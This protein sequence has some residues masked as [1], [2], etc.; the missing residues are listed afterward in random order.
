MLHSGVI[1]APDYHVGVYLRDGP[2][3]QP[4][5][6]PSLGVASLRVAPARGGPSL[7]VA[8]LGVGLILEVASASGVA[9]APRMIAPPA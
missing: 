3:S 2:G 9:P 4:G 5:G 7:G 6:G 8:S 1:I